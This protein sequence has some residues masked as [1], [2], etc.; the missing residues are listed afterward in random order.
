LDESKPKKKP[1]RKEFQE[2]TMVD[3]SQIAQTKDDLQ[4]WKALRCIG[5]YRLPLEFLSTPNETIKAREAS[6]D[7]INK[8][9]LSFQRSRTVNEEITCVI[10]SAELVKL[11]RRMM[12]TSLVNL[13]AANFEV[14]EFKKHVTEA[15]V[16]SGDHS[17]KAMRRLQEVEPS[18][19]LWTSAFC[20]V[21]V[22]DPNKHVDNRMLLM[23]GN[24]SNEQNKTFLVQDF[25]QIID[26]M[27]RKMDEYRTRH[28]RDPELFG[29]KAVKEGFAQIIRDINAT[30]DINLNTLGQWQQLSK[31][32]PRL[33]T[34]MS[35][36][37]SGKFKPEHRGRKVKPPSRA[38]SA[39]HWTAWVSLDYNVKDRLVDQVLAGEM[40]TKMMHEECKFIKAR[41]RLRASI[42]TRLKTL[43]KVS[44]EDPMP[45]KPNKDEGQTDLYCQALR[46]Y[47]W[48]EDRVVKPWFPSVAKLRKRDEI[49]RDAYLGMTELLDKH[50]EVST[51]LFYICKIVAFIF[52]L[53]PISQLI[54]HISILHM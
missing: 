11:W 46:K 23:I 53:S 47:P 44:G 34:K 50:D 41:I 12:Q 21:Y 9:A 6:D 32:S 33:Y 20:K 49:P 26:Q 51:K 5:R 39:S 2:N 4:E 19:P 16:V 24:Q 8:L 14:N 52:P 1:K 38:T 25:P 13:D 27:F 17:I 45:K 42:S 29:E 40:D 28:R 36:I 22:S 7:H 37:L 10:M 43:G 18:E 31:Q 15:Y 54:L 48:L 30:K 3:P 35:K